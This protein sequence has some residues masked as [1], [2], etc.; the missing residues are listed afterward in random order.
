MDLSQGMMLLDEAPQPLLDDMGVD[1]RGRDVGMAEQLLHGAKIRAAL[2]QM[3]G[4]GVAE[5][6]RRDARRLDAGGERER[7]QLLAEALPG[8]MLAARRRKQ[9]G[10]RALPLASSARTAARCVGKRFAGR[11]VQRHQPLA[12]AFALDGQAPGRRW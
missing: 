9:P 11:I 6:M 5:H 7:L 4:E 12:S 10:R 2:Q 3:A 8:Q 1:L